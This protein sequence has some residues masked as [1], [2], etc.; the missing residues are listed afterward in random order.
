[1]AAL[2]KSK[3]TI[4]GVRGKIIVTNAEGE[5][6]SQWGGNECFL[7]CESSSGYLLVVRAA[8]HKVS[9]GTMFR[10]PLMKNAFSSFVQQ[11]KLTVQIPH[12]NVSLCTILITT[13]T[14]IHQLV[15]MGAILSDKSRWVTSIERNVLLNAAK[16]KRGFAVNSEP[17]ASDI[18]HL[19]EA[20]MAA[21]ED[22]YEG[23]ENVDKMGPFTH[24][25]DAW[26]HES[27]GM[28]ATGSSE[29]PTGP[30]GLLS[31][32]RGFTSSSLNAEQQAAAKAFDQG[33]SVFVT[34]GAGTGKSEWMKHVLS[35]YPNREATVVTA[36]TG[37][38]ARLIG[39]STVHSFAGIGLGQGTLD[40]ILARV[41]SRPE[42]VH[43][44]TKCRMWLIDEIGMISK[45]TF[46][47]LDKVA[48]AMKKKPKEAFGGIQMILVGDF[49]QLP[50]ISRG[51]SSGTEP[52]FCFLAPCWQ[53]LELITIEFRQDFR[54]ATDREFSRAMNDVRCGE[55]TERTRALLEASLD[56]ELDLQFGIVP[57]HIMSLTRDVDKFNEEKMKELISDEFQRY[58]A[59]DFTTVPSLNLNNETSFPEVLHLKVD[60]QVVLLSRIASSD[61]QN[62]D[63]GV[64]IGF[65]AQQRGQPMPL[66]RF[67]T[68]EERVI[69]P[70]KTEV[71]GRGVVIA[72]RTQVPICLAWALTVHRVQGMT[73]PNIVV[74]LDNSFFEYG[75][76]Y[77]ALSRVRRAEDLKLTKCDLSGIKASKTAVNFYS[78]LFPAFRKE[79]MDREREK[80]ATVGGSA[81][82]YGKKQHRASSTESQGHSQF[83][84]GGHRAERHNIIRQTN[85][86]QAEDTLVVLSAVEEIPLVA[87]STTSVSSSIYVP[88]DNRPKIILDEDE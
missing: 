31:P 35:K 57:T 20:E 58:T 46:E 71:M 70:V 43:S 23:M 38:A 84:V 8:R 87:R 73:L 30:G 1:M 49:M 83:M 32:N 11:G 4:S 72:T 2:E 28:A 61:L 88:V 45:S 50:P 75:Q 25:N 44:W 36:A 15:M 76:V 10:L 60:A 47:L 54:H 59:E 86:P 13:T 42:V 77:V 51:S 64:V 21:G 3:I 53:A 74:R 79:M 26:C 19:S 9:D 48:R 22:P 16:K 12:M 39:G 81:L 68:G 40:E 80:S 33:N 56:R 41:R 34:G 63:R 85:E 18:R 69:S 82:V 78:R 27:A 6:I 14:D 17:P 55:I 65:L 67:E 37:V 5:K 29:Q 66:I 52:E 24:R 62:G 7:T